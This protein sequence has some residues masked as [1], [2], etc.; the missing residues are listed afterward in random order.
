V[1]SRNQS[2]KILLVED[3]PID[4][5]L[6]EDFLGSFSEA[7]F[8]LQTVESLDAGIKCLQAVEFDAIL[9][10]FSVQGCLGGSNPIA[11]L[12]AQSP[13]VPI[14]VLTDINDESIAL[15]VLRSGAQDCLV[16]GRFHRTLLVRAIH[17]AIERQHIEEQLRQQAQRERLLGKMIENIRSSIDAASILQSTVAEV[18]QFLKTD[19]VLIYRCQNSVSQLDSEEQ[20]SSIVADDGLPCGYMDHQN[21]SAA[22]AMSCFVIAD[23]KSVQA[24]AD[25]SVAE[26]ASNSKEL[27]ANCE[28]AAVLSV[29]IW[30]SEDW[31]AA[32]KPADDTVCAEEY[33]GDL[34]RNSIALL[35]ENRSPIQWKN[36]PDSGVQNRNYLWGILT[37]YN[38]SRVRQWQQWEI[39]FLKH[40]ADQVAIAIEQS[41]LYRQLAIANE[42]LQ[43]LATTDGL[44]GIANRRQFDRILMLEWRRLAREELPLSLMMFDIDFFKLYNDFYGHLAGDDCLQKVAGAI[45][46]CAKRAGDLSARYGGEEF[47]V[48]LPYTNAEGANVV[49][50]TIC[51]RL[52][53]LQLPHARSSIRPYVTISCGIATTIPV[54]QQSPETLIRS[55]DGALFQAKAEGKNRICHA[56]IA[57]DS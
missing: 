2:L 45:A 18:R 26:L 29:P 47:A 5:A 3:D 16:K 4:A 10:D 55:A 34:D 57:V 49:A 20:K 1:L 9:L 51:D 53:T 42:K 37:A 23:S 24:I 7:L 12:K 27:L 33:T 22:L 17:Y 56:I 6:I 21:I 19:R 32:S 25:V 13:T 31:E 48:L 41:Q 39:D 38:C 40:L 8:F 15:S 11:I 14:L 54:A 52:K 44:T 35:G 30:Q 28:I 46:S 50:R 36:P 43:Q